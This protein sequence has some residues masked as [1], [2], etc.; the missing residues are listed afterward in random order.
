MKRAVPLK[1]SMKMDASGNL[2]SSIEQANY[3]KLE[4]TL[5][6]LETSLRVKT[7]TKPKPVNDGKSKAQAYFFSDFFVLHVTGAASV[8]LLLVEG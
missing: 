8:K 1:P 3:Y 2:L 7:K 5:K 4:T 6:N